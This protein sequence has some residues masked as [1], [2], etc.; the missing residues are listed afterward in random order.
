[1]ALA[2]ISDYLSYYLVDNRKCWFLEE[3]KHQILTSVRVSVFIL[4]ESIDRSDNPTS[5]RNMNLRSVSTVERFSCKLRSIK[6]GIITIYLAVSRHR[7]VSRPLRYWYRNVGT[8]N[9]YRGIKRIA[10]Q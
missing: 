9:T 1:L 10:Q 3:R 8:H 7:D 6:T 2:A 4:R 5:Q